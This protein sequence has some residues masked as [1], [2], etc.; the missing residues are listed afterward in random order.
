MLIISKDSIAVR[1]FGKRDTIVSVETI[2]KICF[3]NMKSESIHVT[4]D[5]QLGQS[6]AT[7]SMIIPRSVKVINKYGFRNANRKTL[8][9]EADSPLHVLEIRIIHQMLNES[10]PPSFIARATSRIMIS[11]RC[12]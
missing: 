4:S 6:C 2:G 7:E 9:F 5:S 8:T 12:D 10:D 11:I 1:H 3:F